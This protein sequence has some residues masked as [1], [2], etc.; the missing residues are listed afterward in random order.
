MSQPAGVSMCRESVPRM[1]ELTGTTPVNEDEFT[2]W[3]RP[4]VAVLA[5][6]ASRIAPDVDRDDIVQSALARAWLKRG[7]YD[8]ARGSPRAWLL[9]ITA[10]EARNAAR[11]RRPSVELVDTAAPHRDTDAR[12]DLARALA[13]LTARQ[14]LAVDCYYFADLSVAE[15]AVVMRCS[16][17]TVK[18]TLSDARLR[19]RSHLEAPE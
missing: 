19:L 1:T 5:R 13:A 18:S 16:E 4:H 9:A 2:G 15:T 6:L 10:N 7:L 8:P 11:Q 3:V 14:R 12:V 17:G